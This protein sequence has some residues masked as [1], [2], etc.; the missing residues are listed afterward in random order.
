MWPS[1]VEPRIY[2]VP[3]TLICCKDG[4]L[5]GSYPLCNINEEEKYGFSANGFNTAEILV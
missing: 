2:S 1:R 5:F 3:V 4:F